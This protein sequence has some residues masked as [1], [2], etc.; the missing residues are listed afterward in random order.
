MN[1]TIVAISTSLQEGAISIIRLSGDDAIEI[2][3]KIFSRNL[4]NVPSHTIHYGMI[5][6]DDELVDEVLV[7]VFRAPKTYT[8]EDVVEINCH[9][10]VYVT[11]K[12][13]SLCVAAGA[14]IASPGEFTQRAFLNGRIDLTQAE[15]VLD[16]IEANNAQNT[17]KAI[18]SVKGSVTRLIQPLCEDLLAI[19]AHIEVNIDYPEY[20]DV[21]QLSQEVVLPQ[22]KLWLTRIEQIIRQ[23]QNSYQLKKGINTVILGKPNVGKSSLLNALLEED[24]AIV[25][26]IA[27]TTRDLVEGVVQCKN[28]TLNLIDTAGIRDT[29]DVVEKIG[30]ERSLKALEQ[31]ELILVVLDQSRDIDDEDKKLLAL[32]EGKNRIIV[33]NK[34]DV[35]KL[36]EGVQISATSN[37]I[38]ELIDE[39]NHRYETQIHDSSQTTLNNERQIGLAIAAKNA[40]RQAIE[41]LEQNVELDLV[42]ID[43]QEAYTS[44]K[45]I[46]GEVS[47]EDLLDALFSNFCLG[48]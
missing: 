32:T 41:E 9:G 19:I 31:A 13:L 46:L 14:K 35:Q 4:T 27:G 23:A 30:I 12:V 1:D 11:R 24:K 6:E 22:A 43:L 7:S 10:G 8:R 34:S 29:K 2:A 17:S 18:S 37:D 40:M 36:N 20:E 47:R 48:K 28:V 16:L 5:H 25:T 3:N 15:G 44:L 33:Y 26:D 39:I 45:E 21:E 42:T 38:H